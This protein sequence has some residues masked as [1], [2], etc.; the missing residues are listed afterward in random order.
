MSQQDLNTLQKTPGDSKTSAETLVI[1]KGVTVVGEI[2]NCKFVKLDGLIEGNIENV[3]QLSIEH[4]GKFVGTAVVGNA[5]ISGSVNGDLTVKD[6]LT[7][8]PTGLVD[9]KVRYRE[10]EIGRGG[11][12]VG[13]ITRMPQDQKA[14]NT[15]LKKK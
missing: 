9:G 6:T 1:G 13:K 12:L 15:T 8:S 11:T 7:V 3:I 14:L 4:D 5:T 2:K 10:L